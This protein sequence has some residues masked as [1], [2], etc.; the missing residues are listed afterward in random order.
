MYII[1]MVI[2]EVSPTSLSE[3]LGRAVEPVVLIR[4][5]AGTH[6]AL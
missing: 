5:L 4:R 3:W 1:F 2:I 6:I